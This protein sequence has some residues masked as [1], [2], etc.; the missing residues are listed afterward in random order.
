MLKFCK[1]LTSK[2]QLN[3]VKVGDDHGRFRRRLF[4]VVEPF[5]PQPLRLIPHF[6]QIFIVLNYDRVLVELAV[7]IGFRAAPRVRYPEGEERLTCRWRHV[8][9]SEI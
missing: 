5:A 1:E 4:I 2:I 7:Q 6:Q 3:D 9:A 8:H